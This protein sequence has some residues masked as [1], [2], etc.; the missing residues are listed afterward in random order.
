[1]LGFFQPVSVSAGRMALTD[2]S[3]RLGFVADRAAPRIVEA[4]EPMRV[5]TFRSKF[6][7]E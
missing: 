4:H 6:A 2:R 3:A 7:I 5:R 1:L